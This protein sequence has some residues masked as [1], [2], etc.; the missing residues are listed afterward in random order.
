MV[1]IIS[2]GYRFISPL[3]NLVDEFDDFKLLTLSELNDTDLNEYSSIILAFSDMVVSDQKTDIYIESLVKIKEAEVPVLGIGVGHHLLG[4]LHG[5]SPAYQTYRDGF[6]EISVI[7][8]DPLFDK[9]P[10][11]FSVSFNHASTVSIPVD[12]EL[13]ASSDKSINE[14]MRHNHKPVYGIQF[15]PELSGNFG[16]IVIENFINL[17]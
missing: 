3:K 9:L 2:N 15:Q 16:R 17:A 8:E 6:E 12:F 5:A 10:E 14:V 11:D 7:K 1:L 4:I 13:L